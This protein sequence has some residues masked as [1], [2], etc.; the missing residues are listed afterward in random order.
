M[1]IRFVAGEKTDS[2]IS[3]EELNDEL[4]LINSGKKRIAIIGSRNLSYAHTQSVELLAEAYANARN[5]V[6][7]SGGASG[8][9][10]AVIRGALKSES[11]MLEVILPQTIEQQSED[12]QALLKTI[13]AI[14]ERPERVGVDFSLASEM[15]Y[16][17]IIDSCH[18][19]ICFL[20]HDSNILQKA[21]DYAEDTHKII[22]KF[23]LD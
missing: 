20:Y 10:A 3:L 2:S 4:R 14:E 23:Y 7:T 1:N 8:A 15:C 5:T 19:V 17:E 16:R 22:T 12:M 9:N 13:D 21:L 18:Q 6:V 11:Q